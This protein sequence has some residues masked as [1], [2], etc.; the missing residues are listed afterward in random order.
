MEEKMK[1]N[2]EIKIKDNIGWRKIGEKVIALNSDNQEMIELNEVGAFLFE[3]ILRGVNVE[4]LTKIIMDNYKVGSGQIKQDI[5]DFIL[6]LAS[7]NFIDM[8]KRASLLRNQADKKT[9]IEQQDLLSELEKHAIE[10]MIPFAATFELTDHCNENCI[11]CYILEGGNKRIKISSE[12]KTEEI[13]SILTDLAKEGCLL[14]S[15]T[16][17]EIFTRTDILDIIDF[18]SKKRFVIDLL[19]NGTLINDEIADFLKE[20]TVRRIQI[21]LYGSTSEAHDNITCKTGSFEK[22]IDAIKKLIERNFKV[23]IA[24]L[25]MKINFNERH[26]VKNLAKSL[27]AQFLPSYIITARN[28]GSKD[29]FDLR[30]SNEQLQILFEEDIFNY[31]HGRKPFQEHQFYMGFKDLQEAAPCYSGINCCCIDPRGNV[32]PCNQ[33]LY[34]LG[35]LRN[36]SFSE[37]WHNSLALKKLRSIKVK[38][39]YTCSKCEMLAYCSRCPGLALLEGGDILGPSFENCRIT[40]IQFKTKGDS[41]ERKKGIQ[42]A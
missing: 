37:I 14:I 5:M 25:V 32:L 31:Y 7:L 42:E 33:L 12:L 16:G 34:G 40:A 41:N 38:D 28:N 24:F 20:R 13:K 8:S 29:T 19:T 10:K 2:M 22:T 30:L 9:Y 18:A 6:E 26:K 11:H 17:G 39:L 15:F 4:K 27:G 3:R 21:S 1:L 35:N 36:S 23:E